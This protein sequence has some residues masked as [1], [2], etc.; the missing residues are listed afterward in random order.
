MAVQQPT[1]IKPSNYIGHRPLM[2]PM[3]RY[4]LS[5][6]DINRLNE[7]LML[8]IEAQVQAEADEQTASYQKL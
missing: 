3:R 5:A 7:Q 4:K 1:I 2:A 6:Q 8:R